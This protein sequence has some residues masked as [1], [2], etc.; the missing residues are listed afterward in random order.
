MIETTRDFVAVG[1]LMLARGMAVE[2]EERRV[3]VAVGVVDVTAG[4][5]VGADAGV[6]VAFGAV[7]VVAVVAAVATVVFVAASVVGAVAVTVVG[8]V[9]VVVTL[10]AVR[11]LV[12]VRLLTLVTLVTVVFSLFEEIGAKSSKRKKN[13]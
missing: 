1:G 9:A 11:R 3:L 10:G 5:D 4:T 12:E 2:A 8:A 13:Q 6:A 7:I